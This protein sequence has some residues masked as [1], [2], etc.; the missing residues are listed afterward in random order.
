MANRNPDGQQSEYS[1][2]WPPGRTRTGR[3]SFTRARA[4]ATGFCILLSSSTRSKST[5]ASV[6]SPSA[7]WLKAG[8]GAWKAIRVVFAAKFY[9]NFTHWAD[10]RKGHPEGSRRLNGCLQ[11]SISTHAGS[12]QAGCTAAVSCRYR[13]DPKN[14]DHLLR[15]FEHVED[16]ALVVEVR[17]VSRP[18]KHEE[19]F[20][21]TQYRHMSILTSVCL[22]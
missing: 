19:R 16:F 21:L 14:R 18:R 9:Q 1:L 3:R 10:L 2:A 12:G 7:G 22:K 15:L 20:L 17:L 6:R 13:D 5:R 8:C 4:T 11:V